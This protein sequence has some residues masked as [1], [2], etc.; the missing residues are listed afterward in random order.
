[1]AVLK[2]AR[3]A[4]EPESAAPADPT[5]E[6]NRKPDPA[7]APG[8]GK[9]EAATANRLGIFFSQ[10]MAVFFAVALVFT[11]AESI[12]ATIGLCRLPSPQPHNNPTAS[13]Y[14]PAARIRNVCIYNTL[15]A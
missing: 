9:A 12:S 3:T 10:Q 13:K 15:I 6:P 4:D 11:P 5:P 7:A 8:T 2:P 1:V 14:M